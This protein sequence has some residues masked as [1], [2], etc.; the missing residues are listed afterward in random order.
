MLK[1]LKIVSV[2]ILLLTISCITDPDN[3]DNH[4]SNTSILFPEGR[5]LVYSLYEINHVDSTASNDSSIGVMIINVGNIDSIRSTQV[6]RWTLQTVYFI[7]KSH[8]N[9]SIFTSYEYVQETDS[10]LL[11]RAYPTKYVNH[12]GVLMK[13]TLCDQTDSISANGDSVQIENVDVKNF[14]KTPQIGLKW[15]QRPTWLEY[16][17]IQKEGIFLG[18]KN[19]DCF[20]INATPLDSH[21]T[22][23]NPNGYQQSSWVTTDKIIKTI[24]S[25]SLPD[26]IWDIP[27]FT[28]IELLDDIPASKGT[29]EPSLYKMKSIQRGWN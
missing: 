5:T 15:I 14:C 23:R 16:E 28:R 9:D 1:S 7:S 11:Y 25:H 20:K 2:I 27:N 18:S 10:F 17:I 21:C 24:I 4:N 29:I 26:S 3:R 12:S 8:P 6:H 22:I 19:F 13:R